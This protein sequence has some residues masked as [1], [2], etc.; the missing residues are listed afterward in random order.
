[1]ESAGK[2][3]GDMSVGLQ[4]CW[5]GRQRGLGMSPSAALIVQGHGICTGRNPSI[6]VVDALDAVEFVIVSRVQWCTGKEN[7][8]SMVL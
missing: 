2:M 7:L 6:E 3:C 5:K 4:M 8:N 1:M